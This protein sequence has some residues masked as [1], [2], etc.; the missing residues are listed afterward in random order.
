MIF[1]FFVLFFKSACKVAFYDLIN[2]T[3]IPVKLCT[4]RLSYIKIIPISE[5]NLLA[6]LNWFSF[7]PPFISFLG[8]YL[9]IFHQNWGGENPIK[10]WRGTVPLV[11][12]LSCWNW[13]YKECEKSLRSCTVRLFTKWTMPHLRFSDCPRKYAS[14]SQFDSFCLSRV[15]K[16]PS[17]SRAVF[18]FGSW[19]LIQKIV[20][21][22][23]F[24]FSL[25][26]VVHVQTRIWFDGSCCWKSL[27]VHFSSR[28]SVM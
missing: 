20:S 9:Y 10:L 18:C 13:V 4:W 19:C 7:F 1:F 14:G 25:P 5:V 24:K 11:F 16:S 6:H 26:K 8:L 12:L 23:F 22:F 28:N 3:F 2:Y 21:F 17:W 27:L 15:C